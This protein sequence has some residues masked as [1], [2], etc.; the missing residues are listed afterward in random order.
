MIVLLPT[1]EALQEVKTNLNK[2][3]LDY[4]ENRKLLVCHTIRGKYEPGVDSA[5]E[6]LCGQRM[7]IRHESDGSVL[8]NDVKV[9]N[10]SSG[11]DITLM[12]IPKAFTF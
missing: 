12:A 5:Y 1:D 3:L 2:D 11:D 6:T 8:V 10:I 9:L 7:T 4:W